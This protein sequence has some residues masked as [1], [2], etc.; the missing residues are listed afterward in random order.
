MSEDSKVD[1]YEK[2]IQFIDKQLLAP[3]Q[4]NYQPIMILTLLSHGGEC[5][6]KEIAKELF[7]ENEKLRNLEHYMQVPVYGVLK[8]QKVVMQKNSVFKLYLEL[9]KME[10]KFVEDLFIRFENWK[11]RSDKF[12]KSG[13]LSLTEGRKKAR[14]IAKQYG[15]KTLS[16]WNKFVKSGLKPDDLPANPGEYY[17]KKRSG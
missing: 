9:N 12:K 4:A 16:D 6:K 2:M 17:K 10:D 3:K 7:R 15:L 5:S 13:F 14:E 1:T 8:K 11:N